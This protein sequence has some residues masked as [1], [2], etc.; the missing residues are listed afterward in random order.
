MTH[1]PKDLEI[2]RL[3]EEVSE[4]R[5]DREA[6]MGVGN[7]RMEKGG[8]FVYGSIKAIMAAQR[9]VLG[10]EWMAERYAEGGGSRSREMEDYDAAMTA[11]RAAR[12]Q[13]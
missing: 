6:Q 12:G 10:P 8:L 11:I 1:D 3:R 13:K 2:K 9:L 7:G 4:L 5:K